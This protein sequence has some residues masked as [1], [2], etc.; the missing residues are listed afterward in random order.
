MSSAARARRCSTTPLMSRLAGQTGLAC[1][2]TEPIEAKH[3][4]PARHPA[5]V[6]RGQPAQPGCLPVAEHAQCARSIQCDRGPG[7]RNVAKREDPHS[8][9]APAMSARTRAS[10]SPRPWTSERSAQSVMG[11]H[12][13]LGGRVRVKLAE[14]ASEQGSG[15]WYGGRFPSSITRARPGRHER[16]AGA[17]RR[18]RAAEPARRASAIA[19]RSEDQCPGCAA[20]G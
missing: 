13:Y 12:L 14:E 8:R 15:G 3:G 1:A 7:P 9:A 18:F 17:G 5:A 10:R 11:S 4:R 6:G 20:A 2:A 19:P 16:R